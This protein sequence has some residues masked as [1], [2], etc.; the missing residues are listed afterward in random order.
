MRA[1][2]C[3]RGGDGTDGPLVVSSRCLVGCC[4]VVLRLS[5]CL[6]PFRGV[7]RLDRVSVPC[8]VVLCFAMLRRAVVRSAAVR[9]AL[10]CRA[11]P[12]QA[13]VCLAVASRVAPCCAVTRRVVLSCVVWWSALLR[14]AARRCAVLRCAV[15]RRVVPCFAAPWCVV[16][17]WYLR[18]GVGWRRRWLDWWLCCVQPG[19]RVCGWLVAGGVVWAGATH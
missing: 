12:C 5:A 17:P 8:C 19:L 16:G 6:F 10:L 7:R 11:A 14:C 18:W 4:G 9:A 13:V 15:L 3:W 1:G 2:R